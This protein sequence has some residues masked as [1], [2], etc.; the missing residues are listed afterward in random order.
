MIESEVSYQGYQVGGQLKGCRH[1][2]PTG[3]ALLAV[4]GLSLAGWAFV[5]VPLVAILHH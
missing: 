5:L 4:L 1:R 3:P 2:L